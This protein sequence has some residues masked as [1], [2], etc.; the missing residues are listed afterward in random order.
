MKKVLSLAVLFAGIS[1]A[2]FAQEQV[3]AKRPIKKDRKPRMEKK[4]ERR[5]PVEIAKSKTDRLDKELKFT[6]AQRAEIYAVQLEQ[7]ESAVAHRKEMKTLQGKRWEDMKSSREKM[8]KILT[9]EQQEQ[10]KESY[11]QRRKDKFDTPKREFRK[12]GM[13]KKQTPDTEKTE[14]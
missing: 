9:S 7:A 5:T 6:D 13:L 11:A 1:L 4:I 2:T 10:L 3:D 12:R 8:G 14:S